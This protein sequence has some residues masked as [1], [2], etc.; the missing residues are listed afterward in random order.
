MDEIIFEDY[1]ITILKR[2]GQ[3]YVRYDTG[4]LVIQMKE[5]QITERQAHKA[6]QSEQDAYEVLLAIQ[7][8]DVIPN[9][10]NT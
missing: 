10:D 7:R 5:S 1:G 2:E 6:R 3:L 9:R 8:F 4:E